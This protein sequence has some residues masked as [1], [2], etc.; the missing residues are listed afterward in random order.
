V[1]YYS[2]RGSQFKDLKSLK[3][4]NIFII[5]LFHAREKS[6]G[7]IFLVLKSHMAMSCHPRALKSWPGT[8]NQ[9]ENLLQQVAKPHAM[10][11]ISSGISA[12]Y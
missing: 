8:D 1:R 7:E 10:E 5:Y 11:E 12:E 6:P 3:G 4:E 2:V 9:V